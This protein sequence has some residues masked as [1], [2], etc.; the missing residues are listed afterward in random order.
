[1]TRVD[2]VACL[3]RGGAIAVA[4]VDDALGGVEHANGFSSFSH[5]MQL[6]LHDRS[7]DALPAVGRQDADPGHACRRNFDKT[8]KG[9]LKR[10]NQAGPNNPSLIEDSEASVELKEAL[11]L[12]QFFVGGLLAKS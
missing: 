4:S 5:V 2:G 8:R 12:F 6:L 3:K 1:M 11:F 9:E 10:V 7:E